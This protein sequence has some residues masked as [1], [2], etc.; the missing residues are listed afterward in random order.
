MQAAPAADSHRDSGNDD[1]GLDD[2]EA[3]LPSR[4]LVSLSHQWLGKSCQ[5]W[6]LACMQW[7]AAAISCSWHLSSSTW[8]TDR[9]GLLLLFA[10]LPPA[11]A[12]THMLQARRTL[13][14]RA[15]NSSSL[16]LHSDD[17]PWS[18]HDSPHGGN[19]VSS[20]V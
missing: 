11:A 10:C 2:E 14:G 9:S 5:V 4:V 8:A 1:S 12:V 16:T 18:P 13:P 19:A 3:L 20:Y 7:Q 15:E 17:S 6:H